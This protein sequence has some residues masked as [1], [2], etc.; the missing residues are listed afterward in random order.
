MRYAY[1]AGY[2]Y[3]WILNNDILIND[4]EIVTKLTDVF[5]KDSSVAVVN[6]DIYA[7]GSASNNQVTFGSYNQQIYKNPNVLID[8]IS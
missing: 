2:K 8:F 5:K 1:K 4:K 6:P 7:P 3:A